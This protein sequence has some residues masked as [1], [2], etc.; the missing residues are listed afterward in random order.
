MNI[1]A[2]SPGKPSTIDL[3]TLNI[4][5][6]ALQVLVYVQ[7]TTSW[8]TDYSGSAKVELYSDPKHILEM[9]VYARK[10]SA[11]SYNSEN[12]WLPIGKERNVTGKYVGQGI[13]EH[14][15]IH[16]KIIGYR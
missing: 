2:S 11:N 16:F 7:A 8:I 6:T 13:S 9:Y 4:P 1:S 14:I 12:V 10:Q 3:A 5:D 15:N